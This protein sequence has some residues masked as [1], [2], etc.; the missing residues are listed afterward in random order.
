M[1]INAVEDHHRA[2]GAFLKYAEAATTSLRYINYLH[3]REVGK[4]LDKLGKAISELRQLLDRRRTRSL[5]GRPGDDTYFGDELRALQKLNYAIETMLKVHQ[6]NLQTERKLDRVVPL[7]NLDRS[8][9]RRERSARKLALV[10]AEK[11]P[12]ADY[13]RQ[14]LHQA[15]GMVVNAARQ[16]P[17]MLREGSQA[18]PLPAS[19]EL[20]START[21]RQ[22]AL[23]TCSSKT[24]TG[25]KP[26]NSWRSRMREKWTRPSSTG[27][28]RGSQ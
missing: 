11:P 4:T 22:A 10:Q 15:I 26:S 25:L 17:Q 19:S 5:G 9:E 6:E 20:T 18:V 7:E 21:D 27:A 14:E 28:G 2:V 13:L 1:I 24:P 3:D 23:R 12:L 16:Q 8:W